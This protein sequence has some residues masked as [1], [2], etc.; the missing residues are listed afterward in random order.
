M[1][2]ENLD[3]AAQIFPNLPIWL[4]VTI[5]IW[6]LAWKGLA[7]WKSARLQSKAWFIVLLIVNTMGI[8][9]ILYIFAFSEMGKKKTG[10]K[11]RR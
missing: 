7:L 5:L 10:K 6:S 1:A 3:L 4:I 8:L 11:K 2:F 9:E